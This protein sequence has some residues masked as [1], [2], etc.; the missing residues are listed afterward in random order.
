LTILGLTVDAVLGFLGHRN[1]R[2]RHLPKEPHPAQ[3][4]RSN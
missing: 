1:L 2:W 4:G 3:A